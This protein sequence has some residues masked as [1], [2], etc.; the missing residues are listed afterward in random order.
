[1][2]ANKEILIPG[3][4]TEAGIKQ[5]GDYEMYVDLLADV[6]GIIDK[7]CSEAENYLASGDLKN[8]T[9]I[10][11]SLKTTCRMMGHTS[12]FESFL[13]LE[14]L[15]KEGSFEKAAELAPDVLDSFRALKASLAPFAVTAEC[16]K[17]LFS[18]ENIKALLTEIEE[19]TSDFDIDRAEKAIKKLLTYQCDKELFEKFNQL[20]TYINDLDYDEAKELSTLLKE[21]IHLN[22]D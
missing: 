9:T 2:E 15:G 22:A 16:E 5:C 19:A 1:M 21:S 18:I 17:N 3:I 8:F 14:K 13:E 6:Y 11:L 4:N 7:K 10:A 20:S 12:L